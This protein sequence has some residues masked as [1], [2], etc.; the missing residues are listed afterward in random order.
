MGHLRSRPS[1]STPIQM[2]VFEAGLRLQVEIRGRGTL[3]GRG[4]RSPS[5]VWGRERPL[6]LASFLF[7]GQLG[8]E[9]EG[10]TSS[11][12]GHLGGPSVVIDMAVFVCVF[13]FLIAF[14][15]FEALMPPP[16]TQSFWCE[17][18]GCLPQTQTLEILPNSSNN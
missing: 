4:K 6:V 12:T 9:E 7:V 1:L 18:L 2:A 11:P 3:Q 15:V 5:G 16:W 13:F 8:P 14:T 17:S 10:L